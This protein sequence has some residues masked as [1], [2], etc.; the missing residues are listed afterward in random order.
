MARPHTEV[1][2]DSIAD[3][4]FTVDKDW[5]ITSFNRAAERI[6]GVSK[7]QAIGQKCFD[8]FRADICQTACALRQTMETR[9]NL[10][11]HRI[12]ILNS[13]GRQIQLSISTAVLR[14][15]KGAIV[16][17]VETFRDLSAIEILRKEIS[18]QYS[19]EDIIS[20]NH[21]IKR[22]FGIMQDIATS[23]STVLIEGP[24]GSGKELFAKAIHNLS[25]R[26]NKKYIV[27]NCGALP[28]T[29][30][31]SELFGYVRG[32]FTDAKKD[33]PG[34]FALAEGGTIMLDEIGEISTALQVKLLR[35]LQEK[36][37][38]PLGSIKP[39]KANVRIIASTNRTLADLV[40]MGTFRDD[41]YYRLNIMKMVLPPLKKRR[42]DIPLLVEHF[43][44]QFNAK[45][46]KNI[47]SVS[48]EVMHLFMQHSFPGNI[49]ELE[50]VIEHAFVLC[51]ETTIERRHLP[52]EIL[53]GEARDAGG[54][55]AEG[56]PLQ[57]KDHTAHGP[58]QAGVSAGD[59]IQAAKLRVIVDVLHKHHGNRRRTAEE[60]GIHKATLWR[61]MQKYG[62]RYP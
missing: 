30:L 58:A 24:S 46:G 21:E 56:F 38:E 44:H 2:L 9:K 57:T 61:W 48:N 33:K 29:L 4:V 23:E 34:R 25:P 13:D 14:N 49:R 20:K 1:I 55:G 11:D 52:L 62:I 32:A 50:N 17:G 35:V 59:P 12:N 19:F 22:I 16:G 36:E 26:K 42:E 54:R 18:E 10:V 27:V 41:L 53:A 28:D 37:Y 60:L 47:E 7:R 45:M 8:V 6:T 31:E 40:A 3:G 39:I 43:I 15:D 51:H 5:N